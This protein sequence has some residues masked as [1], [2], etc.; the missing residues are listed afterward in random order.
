[1][2]EVK[3]T[4][5][6]AILLPGLWLL[7]SAASVIRPG[8]RRLSS[9]LRAN[10]CSV[11]E[12]FTCGCWSTEPEGMEIFELLG[13]LLEEYADDSFQ[14]HNVNTIDTRMKIIPPYRPLK[15]DL[16]FIDDGIGRKVCYPLSLFC[17]FLLFVESVCGRHDTHGE[18][19]DQFPRRRWCHI[20]NS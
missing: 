16:K 6:T 7:S 14:L 10:G 20:I 9:L 1:M 13:T 12:L 5:H 18:R 11:D 3:L 2:N 17:A 19:C 8:D 4:S 15:H